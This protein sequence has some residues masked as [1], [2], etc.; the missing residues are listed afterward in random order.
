MGT[1]CNSCGIYDFDKDDQKFD[2]DYG[3]YVHLYTC[4][5]PCVGSDT[6]PP[7]TCGSIAGQCS[8]TCP[9][10]SYCRAKV[11]EPWQCI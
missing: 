2:W 11:S 5:T 7:P 3:C 10:G 4:D 9:A 6:A 1:S 8:G